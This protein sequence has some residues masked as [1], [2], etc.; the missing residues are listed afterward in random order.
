MELIENLLGTQ[1]FIPHGHCYLWQPELVGLHASSDG[2]TAIAYYAI[3]LT[4]VYFTSQRQDIPFPWGFWL[5]GA[6]IASC[7]TTHLM[8]TVT[9]WYPI[10][11]ISGAIKAITA[12][13]SIYAAIALVPIMPQAL[14][15]PSP[16]QLQQI[17]QQL[18]REIEQRQH[19]ET[20]VRHFNARLEQQVAQR[21]EDLRLANQTIAEFV[22]DEKIL[23]KVRELGVD[24]AQG[25]GI[26]KP[27]PLGENRL[28]LTGD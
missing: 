13:I 5:F 23:A 22:S 11:W 25:F 26:A 12:I 2:L 18:Y 6:F 1:P 16:A 15:L 14:A 19:A 21:T 20:K 27:Q 28:R 3:A 17:N 10:Y 24:Y 4:L 9:L 7:S 8:D